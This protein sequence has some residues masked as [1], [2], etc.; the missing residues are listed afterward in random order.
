MLACH[1]K[2]AMANTVQLICTWILFER[3]A[4]VLPYSLC[5]SSGSLLLSLMLLLLAVP[6]AAVAVVLTSGAIW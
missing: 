6:V 5:C 3:V 1:I 2:L 4:I